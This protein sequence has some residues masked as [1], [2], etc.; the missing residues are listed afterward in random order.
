MLNPIVG[1]AN[2]L[3]SSSLI[4]VVARARC[5]SLPTIIAEGG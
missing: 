1:V 3:L 2:A 4:R 5:V